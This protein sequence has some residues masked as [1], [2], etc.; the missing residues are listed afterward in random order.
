MNPRFRPTVERLEDRWCPALTTTLRGG[1]LTISG[2]ADNGAIGIVQDATTAGTITV[3]DGST[4][5]SGSP[6]TGVSNIRLNLTSADAQ[7]TIDLGGQTLEGSVVGN[8]G[9][10]A[11][12]LSVV[13]GQIGGRLAVR[14][15]NEDDVVT[16]GDGTNPLT[17]RDA[18]IRLD[19]GMDTLMVKSG[20]DVT[21][22]L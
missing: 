16:L 12:N 6:F 3:D 22:S 18:D 9:D 5:V 11:N 10:G 19:G 20:V 21:R 14:A 4:A 17:V 8:L 15:G 13:N 1:T 2:S 7:V